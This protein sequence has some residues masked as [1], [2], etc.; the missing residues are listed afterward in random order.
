MPILD[1][2]I[3]NPGISASKDSPH[4]TGFSGAYPTPVIDLGEHLNS[5]EIHTRTLSTSS[6]MSCHEQQGSRKAVLSQTLS[7]SLRSFQGALSSKNYI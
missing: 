4:Q 6:L 5:S 7:P 2:P 3:W 1:P